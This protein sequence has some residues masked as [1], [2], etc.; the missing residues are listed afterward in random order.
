MAG[1][2]GAAHAGTVAGVGAADVGP[3]RA[4]QAI[5]SSAKPKWLMRAGSDAIAGS[6]CVGRDAS[7]GS[8][9]ATDRPAWPPAVG[10]ARVSR[11]PVSWIRDRKAATSW[12]SLRITYIGAVGRPP[13]GRGRR[14]HALG[15]GVAEHELADRQ[16]RQPDRVGVPMGGVPSGVDA[17]PPGVGRPRRGTRSARADPRSVRRAGGARGAGR[18]RARRGRRS[19][20]GAV[21]ESSP[22]QAVSVDDYVR[23]VV[24]QTGVPMHRSPGPVVAETAGAC[25]P[26]LAE[27]VGKVRS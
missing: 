14:R 19:S 16:G 20:V 22:L 2:H 3:H 10:P 21:V 13:A 26:S 7:A 9:R 6:G 8:R 18:H 12:W 25:G 4:A 5:G 17:L 15:V 23:D 11:W 24:A 27:R 1:R